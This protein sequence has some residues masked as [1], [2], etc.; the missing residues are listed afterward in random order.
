MADQDTELVYQQTKHLVEL[1]DKYSK[2]KAPGIGDFALKY[3]RFDWVLPYHEGAIRYYKEI[4]KWTEAA[5]KHNDRLLERQKVLKQ[6]WDKA[7]AEAAEKK[8]KAEDYSKFWYG[9]RGQALKTAGFEP[10]WKAP[11]F[12][13]YE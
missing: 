3:Q 4:G 1:Y 5:Q 11:G 12:V 2:V 7:V 9:I 8:V 6:V 13:P 10:Y